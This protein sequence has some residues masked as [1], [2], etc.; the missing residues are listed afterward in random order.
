[1]QFRSMRYECYQLAAAEGAAYMQLYLPC[2]A[3]DAVARNAGRPQHATPVSEASILKMAAAIQPPHPTR[4]RWERPTLCLP[5]H[6][7]HNAG[8]PIDRSP[9]PSVDTACCD[10]AAPCP[11]PHPPTDSHDSATART[12]SLDTGAAPDG[13]IT[14]VTKNSSISNPASLVSA[15]RG[16]LDPA[17]SC[18]SGAEAARAA[19]AASQLHAV[20]KQS[21]AVVAGA[22]SAAVPAQ[23]R[24]LA[25]ALHAERRALLERVRA[26]PPTAHESGSDGDAG[27]G[28]GGLGAAQHVRACSGAQP[29]FGVEDISGVGGQGGATLGGQGVWRYARPK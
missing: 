3:Q 19:T 2:S 5:A 6:T 16:P 22:M 20:D 11:I 24:Q 8:P 21:R 13:C 26:G 12:S 10:A 18:G 9:A 7:A 25:A 23:R 28:Q 4:F 15:R 17:G 29:G 27:E 1:M 14:L